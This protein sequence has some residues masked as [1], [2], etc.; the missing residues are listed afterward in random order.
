MT[1]FDAVTTR[2]ARTTFRAATAVVAL[3]LALAGCETS[4]GLLGGTTPPP[5]PAIAQATPAPLARVA[6]API[7]GAPE[8]VARQLGTQL[9]EA[10]QP[11]RVTI[12]TEREAKGDYTL[13]GYIV[14]SRDKAGTKVS[15]IFDVADP[16]GRRVNRITGEEIAA[17][18]PNAK[19][20]W[21]A[22]TPAVTKAIADKTASSLATWLPT[23]QPSP[24]PVAAVPGQPPVS[25]AGAGT[26]PPQGG[27]A[28]PTPPATA[29]APLVSDQQTAAIPRTEQVVAAPPTVTGAP[30]DGNGALAAALQRELSR[31]GLALA[32]G[33]ASYRVE[34]T[35]KLGPVKEGKQLIQID[36]RV[37]DPQGKSLG[38][39][40]QKNEIPPGSLDSQWGKTADAAAAAAAQGI[41]KLMPQ[42]RSTN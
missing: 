25:G 23:Q 20:P 21:A 22:V 40:S 42:P 41:L 16:A 26:L 11:Q 29:K 18:A 15:Y 24:T 1:D 8:A 36:W 13:R 33:A 3:S 7:I 35:V 37:K 10:G 5:A 6:L 28:A 9:V 31:Q 32:E 12:L 34:G 39:V 27:P 4:G 14:A 2:H 17:A 19:D 30:G 38:T